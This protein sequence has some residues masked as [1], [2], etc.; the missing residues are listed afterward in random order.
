MQRTVFVWLGPSEGPQALGNI[1]AAFQ[2]RV[3]SL[4]ST[5]GLLGPSGDVEALLS[6]RLL[7]AFPQYMFLL[8][9][10]VPT[11]V[12]QDDRG[13]FEALVVRELGRVLVLVPVE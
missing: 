13:R 4:P 8:S 10:N 7:K 6:A 11:S 3:A 12:A 1:V 2:S 5:S 9:C